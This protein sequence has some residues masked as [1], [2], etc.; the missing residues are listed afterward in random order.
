MID[1]P[2]AHEGR[3]VASAPDL[4]VLKFGTGSLQNVGSLHRVASQVVA[5]RQTGA[6]VVAVLSA[7]GETTNELMRLAGEVSNFPNPR[8]LDM[9]VSVGACIS[10]TLCAMAIH[11]LGYGAVSLEGAQAGVI[12]DARHTK[13][14]ILEIRS[15]RVRAALEDVGIVLVPGSQGVTAAT[16]EVTILDSD[17]PDTTAVALAA[18]LGASTCEIFS[19]TAAVFTADPRVVPNALTLHSVAYEEM[20]E[21]SLGHGFVAPRALEVARRHG[22]VLRLRP[23]MDYHGAETWIGTGAALLATGIPSCITRGGTGGQGVAGDLPKTPLDSGHVTPK[24][25]LRPV[26]DSEYAIVSVIGQDIANV[27]AVAAAMFGTLAQADIDVAFISSSTNR[28]SCSVVAAKADRAVRALHE[29][30]RPLFERRISRA[31][32]TPGR[33]SSRVSTLS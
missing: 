10:N 11:N 33:P 28:L 14:K 17:G 29:T 24:A 6:K 8:E 5:A 30:F 13:A 19:D 3:D 2:G 27:P 4:L 32:A 23:T 16:N 31:L 26:G 7:M 20:L 25:S 1:M 21:M 18:A 12:T 22:V 9:V 15:Q